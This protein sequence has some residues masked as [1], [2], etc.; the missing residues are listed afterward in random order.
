[1]KISPMDIQR[2]SFQRAFRGFHAE[3]VRAYLSIVADEFADL[4]SRYAELDQEVQTLRALVEELYRQLAPGA[5][6]PFGTLEDRPMEQVR[7]ARVEETEELLGWRPSTSLAAGLAATIDWYRRELEAGRLE[8]HA[9]NMELPEY[10]HF[11]KDFDLSTP[12]LVLV[13]LEDGVVAEWKVLGD[14][15]DLI[16]TP[17]DLEDYVRAGTRAYLALGPG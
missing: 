17:A 14:V 2:Q 13:R 6:P 12:S 8:W 16:E 3:E 4:Q 5:E 1:M 10:E 9:H 15:W 7:R 11:Q